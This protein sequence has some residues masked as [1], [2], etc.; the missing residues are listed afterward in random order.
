[1]TM[2][3]TALVF[4]A[5]TAALA[6]PAHAQSLR[7]RLDTTFAFADGAVDVRSI[8]GPV[9]ITTW[10]RKEVKIAAF[11][12]RGELIAELSGS[13]VRLEAREIRDG[14]RRRGMGEQEFVLT[15]PVGTRVDAHAVSGDVAVRGTRSDVSAESVSGDVEVDEAD[16]RVEVSSVSGD[17]SAKRLAGTV[18]VS[19]VSG[20]VRLREVSGS[21]T[22]ESV[23]G[24]I[25]IADAK[26]TSV[27]SETVSGDVTYR[28]TLDA[29]GRY[30][31]QSHS[32]DVTMM[33]PEGTKADISAKTFSG[34][35]ESE[36]PLVTGGAGEDVS[37]KR[38]DRMRFTL[39]GGGGAT[40]DL[41]TFSGSLILRR[42]GAKTSRED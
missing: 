7:Q 22:V 1:M 12:E 15:V 36:F 27:K 37:R 17:V 13:R 25:D 9:T 21:L 40:V 42:P 20:D 34:S 23:S 11:V 10:A 6:Q 38:R 4:L 28:G 18:S 30:A 41:E 32:G 8:S 31:M 33:L 16:G 19:S 3:I 14:G 29:R 2:R 39:G 24:S 5:T 35:I 26:A